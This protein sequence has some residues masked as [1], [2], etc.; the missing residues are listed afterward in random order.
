MGESKG[1]M[2]GELHAL[3]LIAGGPGEELTRLK[4]KQKG[5]NDSI[6]KKGVLCKFPL[7]QKL[8]ETQI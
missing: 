5:M 1:L 6:P 2:E 4:I 8:C 7:P 3:S